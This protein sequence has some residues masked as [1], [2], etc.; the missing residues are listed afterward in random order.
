MRMYTEEAQ[1]ARHKDNKFYWQVLLEKQVF[2]FCVPEIYF[3]MKK[4][5]KHI[6][7]GKI[8]F[9]QL[10][11][12]CIISNP[13]L[14]V[15]KRSMEKPFFQQNIGPPSSSIASAGDSY[16]ENFHVTEEESSQNAGCRIR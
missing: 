8:A 10:R 14:V 15:I 5:K 1:E 9:N 3:Y 6:T 11:F 13:L 7:R 16:L 4:T 12:F 2:L